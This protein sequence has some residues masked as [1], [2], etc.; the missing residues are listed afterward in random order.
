MKD[1]DFDELDRAV[2]SVLGQKTP[3]DQQDATVTSPVATEEETTVS[4]PIST[5]SSPTVTPDTPAVE[6]E[7]EIA[8]S[9]PAP[10]AVTAPAVPLAVKRRG[11]F[12]DMVHP[13]AAM[14]SDKPAVARPLSVHESPAFS[15]QPQKLETEEEK[16]EE[17]PVEAAPIVPSTVEHKSEPIAAVDESQAPIG[18]EPVVLDDGSHTLPAETP[19]EPNLDPLANFKE[20]GTQVGGEAPSTDTEAQAAPAVPLEGEATTES[21][22]ASSVSPV[23]PFLSDTKVEKRPLG[24][25]AENEAK[26]ESPSEEDT[27]TAPAVPLPREL[28]SDVLKVETG[29]T[30]IAAETEATGATPFATNVEAAPEPADDDRVEGHP[31]FD[32]ST[33]HEPIAA[34]PHSKMP[35]WLKWVL[36]LIICLA[37]GAGV[38]YFLFTAGL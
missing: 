13:S 5:S 1:I 25:F 16:V 29:A 31:L 35:T 7:K 2:S 21:S 10:V 20:E 14:T 11:K 12:M 38:G 26:A 17:K 28:Q 19:D 36:G 8:P 32:T 4:T 15:P 24:G 3:T 6:A 34:V 18:A 9:E 27:Q 33:Y 37:L 23:T 30:D 22:L